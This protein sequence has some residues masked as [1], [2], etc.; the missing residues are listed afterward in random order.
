[1]LVGE[2]N[3]HI[4]APG[5]CFTRDGFG[6]TDNTCQGQTLAYFAANSPMKKKITTLALVDSLILFLNIK[7]T[8]SFW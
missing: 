3:L 7:Y 8:H 2:N 6:L 1:M 4:G 5:K